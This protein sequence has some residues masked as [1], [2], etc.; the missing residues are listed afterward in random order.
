MTA[1]FECE[2][3]NMIHH[4]LSLAAM[5]GAESRVEIMTSSETY[6]LSDAWEMII[7]FYPL[8]S[9]KYGSQV[10]HAEIDWKCKFRNYQL[11]GSNYLTVGV[12]TWETQ[13]VSGWTE[14]EISTKKN[15]KNQRKIMTES[16]MEAKEKGF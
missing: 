5:N 3:V 9:W 16:I 8:D 10:Q 7:V 6:W 12:I 14:E 13:Q 15:K 11:M 2:M 1:G 4:G